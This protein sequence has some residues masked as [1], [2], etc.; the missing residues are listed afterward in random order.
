MYACARAGTVVVSLHK[1]GTTDER[2]GIEGL[3]PERDANVNGGAEIGTFFNHWH[4]VPRC[5]KL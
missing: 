4:V 2:D 1:G 5:E 3:S